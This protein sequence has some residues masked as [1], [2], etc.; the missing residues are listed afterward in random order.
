MDQNCKTIIV[1]QMSFFLKKVLWFETRKRGPCV[2]SIV[3]QLALNATILLVFGK[4]GGQISR[5][6]IPARFS[7]MAKETDAQN[8]WQGSQKRIRMIKSDKDTSVNNKLAKR[9]S[10]RSFTPLSRCSIWLGL[11]EMAIKKYPSLIGLLEKSCMNNFPPHHRSIKS[12]WSILGRSWNCAT[13]SSK[14][15]R[16]AM[17]QERYKIPYV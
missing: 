12:E 16:Y 2:K 14:T 5:K 3:V 6:P 1:N 7:N 8:A 15:T 17:L 4:I 10:W 13:I 11:E 9:Q